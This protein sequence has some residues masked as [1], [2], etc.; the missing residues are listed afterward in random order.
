VR[1]GRV[2]TIRQGEQAGRFIHYQQ[3]RVYENHYFIGVPSLLPSARLPT[4]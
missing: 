4:P 1:R 3:G 2:I